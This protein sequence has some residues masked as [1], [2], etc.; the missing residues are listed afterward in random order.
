V[1]LFGSMR[2]FAECLMRSLIA[3]TPDLDGPSQLARRIRIC[4]LQC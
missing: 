3:S 2:H 1:R 4:L